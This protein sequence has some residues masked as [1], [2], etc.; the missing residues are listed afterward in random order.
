V[1]SSESDMKTEVSREGLECV[2]GV[3]VSRASANDEAG[4]EKL[5]CVVGGVVSRASANDEAGAEKLEWYGYGGSRCA[6]D[7]VCEE[8]TT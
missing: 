4:T 1:L 5:E 6:V 3:V 2:V 7:F 8:L